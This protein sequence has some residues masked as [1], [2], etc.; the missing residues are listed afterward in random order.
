MSR[1]RCPKEKELVWGFT[2][3]DGE[4]V[5]KGWVWKVGMFPSEQEAREALEKAKKIVE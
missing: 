3:E 1:E 5:V 2:R 4:L